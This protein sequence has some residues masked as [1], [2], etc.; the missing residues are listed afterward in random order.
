MQSDAGTGVALLSLTGAVAALVP[1]WVLAAAV[2]HSKGAALPGA[3][4][5]CNPR[6]YALLHPLVLQQ[7][8]AAGR[9]AQ[10]LQAAAR[11][12]GDVYSPSATP[13][14]QHSLIVA[15]AWLGM[16]TA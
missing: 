15:E 2:Y 16:E 5:Q 6:V 7:G 10:S 14:G 8:S 4:V 12:P 9:E 1:Q 13:C 11:V 3:W